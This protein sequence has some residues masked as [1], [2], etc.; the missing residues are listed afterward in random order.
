MT[1]WDLNRL[2]YTIRKIT[3]KY[4]ISQLPDQSSTAEPISI[5][6]PSGIDDYINDYYL[7]D[8]PEDLRSLRLR[9]FY[10]FSTIPNCGTYSIPQNVNQIYDPIYVDNYQ[11]CFYQDPVRF[12]NVWPEFN[13]INL[14]LFAPNG[15]T[16]EFSFNFTQTPIQQGTIVIG[17]QPNATPYSKQ[18][19]FSDNENPIPLDLPT[20][21]YF[22]NPGVLTSNL[23]TGPFPP[24]NPGI[25]PGTGTIDYI[26]GA[27]T[28]IYINAPPSTAVPTCHYHPYV[29]SRPRDIMVYQQQVFLRPIPNDVY[30]VKM[31]AYLLPTTVMSSATNA[32]ERPSIDA[33]GNIQG[34]SGNSGSLPSDL[35]Q[36]NEFWQLIAYGAALKIFGEDGEHE[37]YAKYMSYYE[38]AKLLV[39]RKTLKQLAQN[40]IHT[41][42]S[43]LGQHTNLWPPYPYY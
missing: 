20:Q 17:W 33:N 21:Q 24:I 36:F 42:Y 18:E 22:V 16:K 2:R 15:S 40:R 34:F 3:G 37:E 39:Q 4:D 43:D 12:Y 14:N 27:C 8:M 19:T 35:P 30:Q 26:T 41:V 6:N 31:M 38:K 5:S 23:Y 29:A 11:G 28:L 32:P 10:L 7:Y 13:F 9:D 1:T 25:T